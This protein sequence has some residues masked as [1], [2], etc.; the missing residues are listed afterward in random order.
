MVLIAFYT[1]F[2]MMVVVLTSCTCWLSRPHH[3]GLT[4]CFLHVMMGFV[5]DEYSLLHVESLLAHAYPFI[6]SKRVYQDI[7]KWRCTVFYILSSMPCLCYHDLFWS[8]LT[9][10]K[11]PRNKGGHCPFHKSQ[12]DS[13]TF[14]MVG[15]TRLWT[16]YHLGGDLNRLSSTKKKSTN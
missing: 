9:G 16:R 12:L 8:L 13:R 1:T 4:T 5:H 3:I 7:V 15:P 14:G 2:M 11:I 10:L 6:N